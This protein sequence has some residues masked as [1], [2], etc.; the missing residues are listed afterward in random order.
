MN[1]YRYV[2]YQ[3]NK[4]LINKTLVCA[5]RD[6]EK[7]TFPT[8]EVVVY[9]KRII[10]FCV[11][12]HNNLSIIS[13]NTHKH[14]LLCSNLFLNVHQTQMTSSITDLTVQAVLTRLNNEL[15]VIMSMM[16]EAKQS[17]EDTRL[18][19]RLETKLA[20]TNQD[21]SNIEALIQDN[22]AYGHKVYD[23][24]TLEHSAA[25]DLDEQLMAANQRFQTTTHL[26][27]QTRAAYL[28]QR[29]IMW[30]WVAFALLLAGGFVYMYIWVCGLGKSSNSGS[31]NAITVADHNIINLPNKRELFDSQAYSFSGNAMKKPVPDSRDSLGQQSSPLQPPPPPSLPTT[32]PN[33]DTTTTTTENVPITPSKDHEEEEV[34]DED[35]D[36]FG[37]EFE[38]P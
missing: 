9:S 20:Q 12:I 31:G 3:Q 36:M 32:R 25:S 30:L 22:V 18:A 11:N 38:E 4:S 34:G 29:K 21:I 1:V 15:P 7:N 24:I 23:D 14:K 28:R 16:N 33:T 10:C 2:F 8:K 26:A 19:Y 27:K 13:Q 37:S 35:D 17:P 5:H 6:F